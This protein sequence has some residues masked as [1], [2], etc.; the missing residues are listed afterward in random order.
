MLVIL[1]NLVCQIITPSFAGV[2][3]CNCPESANQRQFVD[4]IN[5]I[6]GHKTL[7]KFG[8]FFFFFRQS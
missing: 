7:R 1:H 6:L 4:K 3:A 5:V 8:Y 2:S